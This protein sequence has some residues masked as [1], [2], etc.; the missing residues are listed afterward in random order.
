MLIANTIIVAYCK[1]GRTSP[2]FSRII[3]G[4]DLGSRSFKPGFSV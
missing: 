4:L 3:V 2:K 1:E